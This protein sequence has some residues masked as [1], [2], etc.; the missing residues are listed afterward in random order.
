MAGDDNVTVASNVLGTIGTVLWCIQLIPQIWYNWKQKKTDGLPPLMMF[1]WAACAVPMGAYMILQGV[2]I[3]LQIQP[4]IFGFF[5]L[6]SWGQVLY[7]GHAADTVAAQ[8]RL[9]LSALRSCLIP[10][11]KGVTWP[12][13]IVG[14][15]AAILLGLGL[16]PP[17]F[18]LW[19]RDGRV[20]GFNWVFLS[21]DTFGG[22]FSLFALAAQGS[23]DVL[24]GIMYIVVVV[25]E[26]GIYASHIV[27]RIRYRAVR[28]EAKATGKSID[29]VL[30]ERS[31]CLG[32]ASD[33]GN[34]KGPVAGSSESRES[35]CDGDVVP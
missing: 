33:P 11:D 14:I 6:V 30:A 32:G 10:Y 34:L 21:I 9:W 31:R 23:F 15:V 17:Y 7:Y 5:S 24:G 4:Q 25:L 3:P 1:L 26:G 2:N 35:G 19:K 27:W 22:L 12:D 28:R 18:E 29:E 20:V 13:L 16:V 8:R